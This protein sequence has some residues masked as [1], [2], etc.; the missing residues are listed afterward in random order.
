MGKTQVALEL[1]YRTKDKRPECSVFWVSATNI[2]NIQQ[3]YL[4]I[5]QQLRIP[6]VEDKK[7]DV[8]ELVRHYL[9]QESAG[10]WLLV[11]DNADDLDMWLKRTN[12]ST[13][14][15]RLID[16]LPRSDK[17]SIVFTTRSRKA[18]LKFAHGNV[19]HV[20]EMDKE[21]AAQVLRNSLAN[22]EVLNDSPTVAQLLRLLTFLPL[23]IVQ[24]AAYINEND[25]S[26]AEYVSLFDDHEENI[27]EVLSEEFEDE[28]RYHDLK[29]PIAAT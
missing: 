2:E 5:A 22:K 15:T 25:I 12:S 11:L 13:R 4:G 19:I 29:N 9:S 27:I 17:G 23:A 14:S 3:A 10:Q 6:G 24:A 26:L 21:A 18:A 16:L 1:A 7:E 20:A 28:G 8:R